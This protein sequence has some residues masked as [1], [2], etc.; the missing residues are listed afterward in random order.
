MSKSEFEWKITDHACRACLGRVLTRRTFEGKRIYRCACC[1]IEREGPG[2][3]ELC[4]CGIKL[5]KGH[6]QM[7]SG[8]R[9]VSNPA[10]TPENLAEI[11]AVSVEAPKVETPAA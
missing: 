6:G 4:C 2:V 8:I 9:C 11:V 3:A 5:R 1:G 10:R 7:D